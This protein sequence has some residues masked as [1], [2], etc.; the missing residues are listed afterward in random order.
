M[1]LLRVPGVVAYR[2]LALRVV[3]AACKMAVGDGPGENELEAEAVSAVGEAFNNIAIHGY[4]DVAPGPVDIEI[5][6]SPDEVVFEL[7]DQ[8][9]SFDPGG[10]AP[11]PL[12]DLPEGGMGLFIM[13]SFMDLVEYRPGPPNILRLVKRIRRRASGA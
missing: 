8:G 5:Q 7:T 1:I 2:S 12:D 10:V 4:A 9:K 11:P 13:R 3:T 6:W